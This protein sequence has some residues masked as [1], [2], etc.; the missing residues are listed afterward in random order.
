MLDYDLIAAN[1]QTL[2]QSL[3][4][5][6]PI[7]HS[8][9]LVSGALQ[10]ELLSKLGD[11]FQDNFHSDL[12]VPETTTY[13]VPML[14]TPRYKL[15][16]HAESVIEELHEICQAQTDCLETLYQKPLG[17]FKGIVIWRDHT[18]Y[19]LDWHQDNPVIGMSI[20][21]YLQGSEH[22]PG[23]EFQIESGNHTVPFVPNTGYIVDQSTASRPWHRVSG[24]VPKDQVRYSLFVIWDNVS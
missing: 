7:N 8:L 1:T 9:R 6:Q 18:G 22:N 13:G 14:K 21:I 16:W 24:Q 3:R 17:P 19:E 20:Q 2:N 12:W 4:E 11:Y 23:T 15:T 5:S 10:L